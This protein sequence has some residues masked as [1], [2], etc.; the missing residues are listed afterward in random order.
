VIIRDNDDLVMYAARRRVRTAHGPIGRRPR[1]P[2]RQAGEVEGLVR[3]RGG[4]PAQRACPSL[5][6]AGEAED[7][8]RVRSLREVRDRH[9]ELDRRGGNDQN[10]RDTR[11]MTSFLISLGTQ[12]RIERLE[13][14]DQQQHHSPEG[15]EPT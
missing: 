10:G 8:Q 4:R 2:R 7:H 3:E 15:F 6:H 1:R 11:R 5:R 13:L 12:S 14:I 9:G